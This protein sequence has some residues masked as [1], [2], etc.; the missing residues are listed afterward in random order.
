M[1]PVD[2]CCNMF[3]AAMVD[4]LVK[5]RAPQSEIHQDTTAIGDA[6]SDS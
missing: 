1:V 4:H 5:T 2:V 3:I 6:P